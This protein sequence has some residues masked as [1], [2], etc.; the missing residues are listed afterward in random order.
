ME[1]DL[2]S[3]FGLL[4]TAVPIGGNLAT[5]PLPPAMQGLH[6]GSY[7]RALL[8][9]QDRR[10]LYVTPW[11][12]WKND[13]FSVLVGHVLMLLWEIYLNF[14]Y[15]LFVFS[16]TSQKG[17]LNPQEG[18]PC[19]SKLEISYFLFFRGVFFCL[20]W[21][22]ILIPD[23]ASMRQYTSRKQNTGIKNVSNSDPA[24]GSMSQYRS[25]KGNTGVK[26]VSNSDPAPGSMSGT[27]RQP[28]MPW[29]WWSPRWASSM[30][31]QFPFSREKS[32]GKVGEILNHLL[33]YKTKINFT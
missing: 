30:T 16:E 31:S 12:E 23:K 18:T 4:C 1:L 8:V 21:I 28:W 24:P 19:S 7:T 29:S 20:S 9:S 32:A 26:N 22:W 6:L 11:S 14:T 33:P 17:I 10:H 3:L 5:P 27:C 2:Q 13:I 15:L 25:R